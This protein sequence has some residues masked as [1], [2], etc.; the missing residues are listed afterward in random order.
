MLRLLK[1]FVLYFRK[2]QTTILNGKARLI[3]FTNKTAK[4]IVPERKTCT[5]YNS[6][7]TYPRNEN[8]YSIWVKSINGNKI[9]NNILFIIER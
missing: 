2:A 5:I 6:F 7:T 3:E 4:F 8:S 1:A 9:F